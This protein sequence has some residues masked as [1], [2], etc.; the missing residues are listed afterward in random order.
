MIKEVANQVPVGESVTRESQVAPNLSLLCLELR[1]KVM[2]NL[3]I[4]FRKV[5][6]GWRR[7]P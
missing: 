4:V 2:G 6:P 3:C 1:L 7:Y 5:V